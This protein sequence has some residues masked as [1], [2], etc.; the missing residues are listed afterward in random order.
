MIIERSEVWSSEC[1]VRVET[2]NN[3][4][5]MYSVNEQQNMA[6]RRECESVSLTFKYQRLWQ[7]L[8]NVANI[9]EYGEY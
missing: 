8:E 1:N 7:I 2:K 4:K 6:W 3:T 5:S 9:R